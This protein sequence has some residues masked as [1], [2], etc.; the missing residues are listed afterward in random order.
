IVR[1]QKLLGHAD[2]TMTLRYMQ[3]A[4]EAYLDQDAAAIAAHMGGE[5][6]QETAARVAAARSGLKQA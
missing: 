1:L 5:T 3:H 4:P 6:D 2:P